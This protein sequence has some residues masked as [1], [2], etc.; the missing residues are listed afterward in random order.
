MVVK[1]LSSSSS[2]S[3]DGAAAVIRVVHYGNIVI[4]KSSRWSHWQPVRCKTFR[5]PI[6]LHSTREC[7][8]TCDNVKCVFVF[9][10]VCFS[11]LAFEFLTENLRTFTRLLVDTRFLLNFRRL[12]L[13]SVGGLWICSVVAVVEIAVVLVSRNVGFG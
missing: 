9:V 13:T 4:S 5:W 6:S 1:S 7:R 2:L 3:V 10:F 11:A 12:D 8:G